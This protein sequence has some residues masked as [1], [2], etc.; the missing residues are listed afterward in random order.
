MFTEITQ[1]SY[2][3]KSRREHIWDAG[4]GDALNCMLA[5]NVLGS[6]IV[7]IRALRGAVFDEARYQLVD[8]GTSTLPYH[9]W[10]VARGDEQWPE[11]M[12]DT[13][14]REVLERYRCSA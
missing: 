5:G 9:S 13:D 4:R 3:G 8:G 12:G 1:L 6:E 7:R 2:R 11:G 14:A 10:I